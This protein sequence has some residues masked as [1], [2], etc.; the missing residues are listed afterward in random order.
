MHPSKS[1]LAVREALAPYINLRQLRQI[2]ASDPSLL[3]A[4]LTGV[5]PPAEVTALL[6]VLAL[7][8]RPAP[9]DQ[10]RT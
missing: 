9:R 5:E 4:T 1:P 8:L 6:D 10:L 3:T 2:A 7:L